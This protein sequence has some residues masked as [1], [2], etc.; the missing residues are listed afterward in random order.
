MVAPEHWLVWGSG[1][2]F[3]LGNLEWR[4]FERRRGTFHVGGQ[5]SAG[6]SGD[7]AKGDSALGGAVHACVLHPPIH[8]GGA[9]VLLLSA[10]RC[11]NAKD[12]RQRD[13]GSLASW[14]SEAVR[15]PWQVKIERPA[16]G[17]RQRDMAIPFSTGPGA[18]GPVLLVPRCRGQGCRVQRDGCGGGEVAVR[19]A[20]PPCSQSLAGGLAPGV[21]SLEQQASPGCLSSTVPRTLPLTWHPCSLPRKPGSPVSLRNG[22]KCAGRRAGVNE[23]AQ[24]VDLRAHRQPPTHAPSQHSPAHEPHRHR[25]T[26]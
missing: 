20:Q 7:E 16:P 9:A 19:L 1:C 11:R 5:I 14:T 22:G 4:G 12:G 3:G 8:S 17:R 18:L 23:A 15:A 25:P 21:D 24:E 10:E 13:S 2:I 6:F 26:P